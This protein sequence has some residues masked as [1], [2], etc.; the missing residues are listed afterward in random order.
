MNKA[1]LANKQNNQVTDIQLI[2][3]LDKKITELHG[4]C[5]SQICGI[6]SFIG[7]EGDDFVY[8]TLIKSLDIENIDR[9]I[10]ES[11]REAK[12]SR[13]EITSEDTGGYVI[14][15]NVSMETITRGFPKKVLDS[16]SCGDSFLIK[17]SE[18]KKFSKVISEQFHAKTKKVFTVRKVSKSQS[19]VWRT[20]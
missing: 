9:N 11:L 14:E 2:R 12:I 19:R 13:P 7:I 3:Q 18:S 1:T 8:K 6:K 10:D 16:L 20:K 4:F 15:K 17:N 5:L